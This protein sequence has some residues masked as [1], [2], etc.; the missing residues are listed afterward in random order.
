[1]ES[2]IDARSV[3]AQRLR[4]ADA[5]QQKHPRPTIGSIVVHVPLH[6][7]DENDVIVRPRNVRHAFPA[8]LVAVCE[9][10]A[11]IPANAGQGHPVRAVS[12]AYDCWLV[13][14]IH[15]ANCLISRGESGFSY[16]P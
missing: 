7:L 14:H 6:V 10:K 12:L 5:P 11:A 3:V 1:M 13:E 4:G 16:Y 8:S 9:G 15:V 2:S